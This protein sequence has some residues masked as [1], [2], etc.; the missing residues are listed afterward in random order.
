MEDLR[1]VHIIPTL[2]KGGAERIAL[3]ICNTLNKISGIKVKLVVFSNENAFSE[4]SS[5]LDIEIIAARYVPSISSKAIDETEALRN[6]FDNFKPHII[7]THLFEADITSRATAYYNAAY[8]THC[9]YNTVEYKAFGPVTLVNKQL[10]TRYLEKQFVLKHAKRAKSNLFLAVS[11]NTQSYFQSNLPTPF[12]AS[13]VLLHNAINYNRFAKGKLH[14]APSNELRL[15]TVGSVRK[16]KNHAYLLHVLQLLLQQGINATLT[17]VGDGPERDNLVA[18]AI[19]LNCSSNLILAGNVDNVEDYLSE[20]HIYLHSSH[21]ESFGLVLVEAMAAGLP[22]IALDGM[23]NRDVNVEGKTGYLMPAD[24]TPEAFANKIILLA[25]NKELYS[26][27][28]SYARN[29]ASGFDIE[30]YTQRLMAEY[31]KLL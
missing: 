31:K 12:N 16:Y 10:L 29:F 6:F 15:I 9:H 8:I 20:A 3:D 24:T 18:L 5:T 22:V 23:G 11:K 28:S 26:Q 4:L 14:A 27:I 21:V 2:G 7:H 13:V 30:T 1:I 25:N 19:E 17:I